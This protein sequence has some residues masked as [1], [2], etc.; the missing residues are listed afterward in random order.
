MG[1]IV[2][3][4]LGEL[5]PLF[6]ACEQFVGPLWNVFKIPNVFRSLWNGTQ[7]TMLY[8]ERGQSLFHEVSVIVNNCVVNPPR[9]FWGSL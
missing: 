9:W 7:I 6:G 1:N 5:L 2:V 4:G 8:T 3:V